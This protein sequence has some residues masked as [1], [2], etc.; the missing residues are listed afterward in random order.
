VRVS[1][2]LA[3][4][5]VGAPL[6]LFTWN[7]IQRRLQTSTTERNARE[8]RLF[9]GLVFLITSMVSLFDLHT[10]VRTVLQLPIGTNTASHVQDLVVAGT[11]LLVYGAAW[12]FYARLGWRE[13]A[14]SAND[15]VHDV[16]VYAL[17]ATALIFLVIGLTDGIRQ[18]VDDLQGSQL[19]GGSGQSFWEIWGGTLAW[20][21][22]GGGVWTAI[23]Q[24]DLSRGGR[25][26]WRVTYLNIVLFA[27]IPVAV[28]GIIELLYETARRIFGYQTSNNWGFLRDALPLLLIGGSIAVYHWMVVCRQNRLGVK[29]AAPEAIPWPRRPIIAAVTFG[30]L[31]MTATGVITILWLVLDALFHTGSYL[32]GHAWARDQLCGGIVLTLVGSLLWLAPWSI[33]QRAVEVDPDRERSARARRLLIGAT[34]LIGAL[35]AAGFAIAL[36]WFILQGILIGPLDG[37]KVN[38]MLRSIS[39]ALVSAGIAAYYGIIVRRERATRV[40]SVPSLPIT[41]LLAPGAANAL[42]ELER[43]Y[44]RSLQVGGYLAAENTHQ[45]VASLSAALSAAVPVYRTERAVLI[46]D[47]DGGT[48]YRYSTAPQVAV[49]QEAADNLST[50]AVNGAAPMAQHV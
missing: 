9:L 32:S 23:W 19:L 35:V 22:T 31:V 27:S 15:E 14:P 46:L 16:A 41:V 25:R 47:Q 18:I 42:A 48:L 13:R 49:E 26:E 21:L 28:A 37:A 38:E 40:E 2:L 39:A 43:E 4:L 29:P 7:I 34:T 10:L 8:R 11:G 12:L 33:L 3:A 5:L 44:G 17:T 24:Y 50:S 36:V 30:G 6:W 1:Y 45:D 20:V